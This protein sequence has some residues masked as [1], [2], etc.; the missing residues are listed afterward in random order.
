MVAKPG[1]LPPWPEELERPED[2]PLR[3]VVR[4]ILAKL[5]ATAS[6]R[7]RRACLRA[8]SVG[9]QASAEPRWSMRF[10]R[11][12][13]CDHYQ[14]AMN[15]TIRPDD[16]PSRITGNY[17]LP[18]LW[19][20]LGYDHVAKRVAEELHAGTNLCVL[21]GP[22]GVGKSWLASDIGVLWE[23]GGGSTVLVEGDLQ[24]ADASLY[25]FAFAM[26]G[27]PSRWK[28]IGPVIAG[29]ARAGEVLVGT[30]GIITATVEALAKARGL[31]RRDRT[32]FLGDPEQLIL[33]ELERLAKKR[34]LLLIADNLHWWDSVSLGLLGRL[35]DPRMWDAFPF[36]KGLRILAAQTPEPYQSVVNPPAHEA[37][38]I[39]STTS[40]VPLQRVPREHFVQVLVA[41]GAEPEPSSDVSDAI[42]ALSGGH[43]A[44]AKRCAERITQ[45]EAEVFLAASTTEAFVQ[46]LLTERMQSLGVRGKQAIAL[47]EVA[48]L[49]GSTFRRDEVCCAAGS[50][51]R[52]TL[53]LLRY[54]R[55]EGVLEVAD[56][57]DRFVH[58]IYRQYF[59]QCGGP[60]KAD[61][62]ERLA[63]CLRQSRPA[64]YEI[65]CLNAISAERSSEAAAL[66]VHAALQGERDGRSWKELP[67]VIVKA[68]SIGDALVVAERLTAALHQLRASRFAECMTTLD[69][70]PRSMP[71]S[72]AAEAD[73]LRA[74]CFLSTRSEHDRAQGRSILEGWDGYVEEE[75]EL[76]MRLMLLLLYGL[77]HLRDKT[78]GWALETKIVRNLSARASFDPAAEDAL[79]TLD[80]CS[81]GL[82]PQD[83]SLVRIREAVA[84]FGP[85]NGQSVLRRPVEYYRCLV[86]LAA[87]LIENA[88]YEEA[89]EVSHQIMALVDSYDPGV[90]SRLDFPHTNM[91][92]AEYRVRRLGAEDA[93]GRQ[94]EIAASHE[95]ADDPFYAQNALAVYLALAGQH[96]EALEI[97]D[98]LGVD[99][100]H[101]RVEPEPSMVYV[102]RANRCATRF[103]S[104]DLAAAQSEWPALTVVAEASNYM[105]RDIL[106]LRHQLMAEVIA[107]GTALTALGFDE[108]LLERHPDR[109]GPL[110]RNFGHG[111]VLPA[112]ELWREN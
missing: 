17:R 6:A 110:W 20:I 83:A 24:R 38:L 25:P 59:L 12:A 10:D 108:Y 27:L 104:G 111:F 48:A 65:R 51:E 32:M 67:Q 40:H 85:G 42:Y 18:A 33:H 87:K 79:Y 49:L 44:L 95:P 103:V 106:L 47:L 54:C 82:H 9:F 7:S 19:Q 91:V 43:L 77:F 84:H 2:T 11:T 105:D 57:L 52:Q 97:F 75:P 45:G 89:C 58:D 109:L 60:D 16:W 8:K 96:A 14:A 68:M 53:S 94:R 22:P 36:L 64:E 78:P 93:V 76:G 15:S 28:P 98:R 30:A 74:M 61:I 101:N 4:P 66:A 41:L 39:P 37:L 31:R 35:R 50:E 112:V 100:M 107:G 26:G 70:L 1:V 102:I 86:N 69:R 73:W 71:R 80:R 56:G 99:L 62:Y 34:P 23:E 81:G 5:P 72:L 90:F 46:A 88:V 63:D 55:G 3:R 13:F 29:V 21:E 92:Q